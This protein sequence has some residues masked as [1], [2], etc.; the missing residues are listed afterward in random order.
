M[1]SPELH[2][3]VPGPLEQRTGGYIY[4]AHAVAGLRDLGWRVEVHNLQGSFPGG[5]DGA[6]SA[7]MTALGALPNGAWVVVDGLAMGGFPEPIKAHGDRLR[8]LALVHHPLADETGL[9]A[10]DKERFTESERRALQY[11]SGVIVTSRY[12][13]TR[14]RDYGVEPGR[15]RAVL[16][17]TEPARLSAGPGTGQ[18]PALLCVASVTRRK[19]HDVLVRALALVRDLRW[20]CVC[21]GSLD[22]DPAYAR[23]VLAEVDE[24]GLSDRIDFVGEYDNESLDTL[25]GQSSLFVLASY[26]EGYGMALTEALARGIPVVSTTGGAIPFTVPDDASILVAPGDELALAH[27]LRRLLEDTPDAIGLR[28]ELAAAARRR[29]PELPSWIDSALAFSDAVKELSA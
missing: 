21:A 22:R 9:S 10:A 18:P 19:G 12:T 2:V 7:L 3:L 28:H 11:C 1:T 16:P 8:I 5:G 23:S 15:I 26:Y 4:D 25:Y 27:A 13:A 17:G 14:M 29:T 6:E 20:T 24:A